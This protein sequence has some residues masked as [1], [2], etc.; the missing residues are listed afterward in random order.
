MMDVVITGPTDGIEAAR[1][2]RARM[3][4]PVVF[5]TA[6]GDTATLERAKAVGP[7]GYLL[8]PF[9]PS[10]LRT[11]IEVSLHKHALET[12]VRDSERWLTRTLQCISDGIIATDP[13]GRIRFMNPMAERLVGVDAAQAIGRAANDV[14]V[15]MNDATHQPLPDLLRQAM[16]GGDG[17]PRHS[18]LLRAAGGSTTLHVDAGSAPI[19]DDSG[20]L[21]GGVLVFRDVTQVRLDAQELANYRAHLEQLVRERTAELEDA[22][23]RAE[24]A[25]QAKTDF[26]TSMSHELR[27]PMNAV[28]G[29]SELLALE[30]L[31]PRQASYV[32]HI[33]NAGTHLLRLIDDLLDLS[34]I[35]AGHLEIN[36]AAV[37]LDDVIGEAAQMVRAL[38]TAKSVG[39]NATP[40][41][42]LAVQAD[43]TRVVQVLVN[44]LSNGIKY[45]HAGGR[46][47][48]G[49]EVVADGFVRIAVRDNGRG[50]PAQQQ[51][52][53]FKQFERLG[54]YKSGVDGAGIG[55]AHS[56]RMVELMGGRMGFASDEDVGSVFW[57]E[58]KAA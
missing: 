36:T 25:S 45:N 50:I 51:D 28:I 52:K 44:L 7:S 3:D 41:A 8:K 43:A 24:Q 42:G 34:K 20:R 22:K 13:Q 19:R 54:A 48:V 46:V 15:L 40:L 49:A 35:A 39:V 26:L 47:E 53:V 57:F 6:Y 58:L 31:L 11:T 9:R 14:F 33:N 23:H 56:K 27:T 18:G 29:F 17:T 1:Q 38:A 37:D 55:L 12:K 5:L 21:L 10:D 16:A 30:P 2:I 32:K 4:V